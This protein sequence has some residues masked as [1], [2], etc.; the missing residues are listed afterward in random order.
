MPSHQLLSL[1][2]DL[3]IYHALAQKGALLAALD[4]AEEL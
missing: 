2:E 3:T 1:T 4:G